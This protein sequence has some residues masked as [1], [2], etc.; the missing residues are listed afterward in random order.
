MQRSIN[1]KKKW[2]QMLIA[3]KKV[4]YVAEVLLSFEI[5]L[6]PLTR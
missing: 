5:M 3:L 6:P 1:K 2:F 4:I